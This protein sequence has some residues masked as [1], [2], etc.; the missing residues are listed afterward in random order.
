MK[1]LFTTRFILAFILFTICPKAII[2]AQQPAIHDQVPEYTVLL[3]ESITGFTITREGANMV[4][5]YRGGMDLEVK[6]TKSLLDGGSGEIV[7]TMLTNSW[8]LDKNEPGTGYFKDI[9]GYLQSSPGFLT[10]T[11][12]IRVNEIMNDKNKR[13]NPTRDKLHLEKLFVIDDLSAEKGYQE[14]EKEDLN[15]PIKLPFQLPFLNSLKDSLRV[16]EMVI[17]AR[18]TMSHGYL[19]LHFDKIILS[20]FAKR[21]N[22]S[23]DPEQ[24][25][26]SYHILDRS[27]GSEIIPAEFKS[28]VTLSDIVSSGRPLVNWQLETMVNGDRLELVLDHHSPEQVFTGIRS[29]SC[30]M[31]S[32][33][34]SIVP[35]GPPLIR[36]SENNVF[37][38]GAS[39]NL[40]I[41]PVNSETVYEEITASISR[42]LDKERLFDKAD[43]GKNLSYSE[44]ISYL[45]DAELGFDQVRLPRFNS[46]KNY[47]IVT[48]HGRLYIGIPVIIQS[49]H[50]VDAE[51]Y[52]HVEYLHG[53]EKSKLMVSEAEPAF[54]IEIISQ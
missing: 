28:P 53:N 29:V 16:I 51:I 45:W 31:R 11:G 19:S 54:K 7:I 43:L 33:N 1:P 24:K 14:N 37:I 4:L 2:K 13:V 48:G 35:T 25:G 38:P 41:Q 17:P 20:E 9:R 34:G 40:S 23:S 44:F 39:G 27:K 46:R 36:Y 30:I 42:A 32:G 22:S 26:L 3:N 21:N 47:P 49:D 5:P 50:N 12:P 18:L 8:F 10:I 52:F 6:V 15:D